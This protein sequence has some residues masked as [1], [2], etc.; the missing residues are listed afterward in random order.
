MK[1]RYG[2]ANCFD[3]EKVFFDLDKN[4]KG[5]IDKNNVRLL[6]LPILIPKFQINVYVYSS[7]SI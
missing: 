7:K 3:F 2:Q 6:H 4:R 5:S 1:K